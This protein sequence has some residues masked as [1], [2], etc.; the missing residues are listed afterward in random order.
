MDDGA[1]GNWL[2]VA[3]A[4]CEVAMLLPGRRLWRGRPWITTIAVGLLVLGLGIGGSA[5]WA[6]GKQVRLHPTPPVDAVLR[7]SGAYRVVRHPMYL[8]MLVAAAGW[9]MLRARRSSLVALVGMI[10]VLS[11]KATVEERELL[12][13][14]PAAYRQYCA[15]TPRAVPTTPW[16]RAVGRL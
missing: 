6:L 8:G 10:A 12:T 2:L 7:T 4:A 13:R 16:M 14:F 3:Q 5:A 9:A 11:S 1:R 15:G